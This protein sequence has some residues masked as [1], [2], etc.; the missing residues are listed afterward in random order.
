VL[1]THSVPVASRADRVFAIEEGR[2]V[3]HGK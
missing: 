3:P 2:L 1:A